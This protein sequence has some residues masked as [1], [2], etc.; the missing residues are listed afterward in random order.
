MKKLFQK[1]IAKQAELVVK[2]HKPTIISITGS[3]GKT[4][5]KDTLISL[6][7][8]TLPRGDWRASEKSFNNEFGIPLTIL[9]EK[10]PGRSI[11]NWLKILI[12]GW[13]RSKKNFPKILILEI[14]ADHPGDIKFWAEK[15][16]PEISI[17]TGVSTVH[18]E[19]YNSIDEIANEK[20]QLAKYASRLVILNGDDEKVSKMSEKLKNIKVLTYGT[21]NQVDLR[22]DKLDI[23]CRYDK[24][25]KPNDLLTQTIAELSLDNNNLGELRLDNALGYAPIFSSMASLLALI[26]LQ[27]Y[28][29]YKGK[30]IYA[31]DAI[32]ILRDRFKPTPGRLKPLAGIKGCLI[33]DDTYNAA[34][35]AMQYGLSILAGLPLVN[36][37]ARRIAVLGDM[38]ELGAYTEDEHKKIGKI[39]IKVADI[40]VLVG[41]NML[42]AKETAIQNGMNPDRIRWFKSSL[43]AGRYLDSEVKTGDLV[44]VK[45]SQSMRMERVV[46]D[47]MAEPWLAQDLLIRQEKKWLKK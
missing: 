9:G 14:G 19:Y 18:A 21:G 43:E 30:K 20:F 12:F 42:I 44:Y 16:K 33:I 10:A 1:I 46:K 2:R 34:P 29:S 40:L 31:H 25:F 7:S 36:E 8:Q 39:S 3:Y 26:E 4:T 11:S 35:A 27:T 47:I 37:K 6:I 13:F 45:G 17:I 5:T 41:E 38:A 24:A 23:H 15:L 28:S 22:L 32:R